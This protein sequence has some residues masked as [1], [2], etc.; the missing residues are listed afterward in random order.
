MEKAHDIISRYLAGEASPS[1]VQELINWLQQSEENRR[2]YFQLKNIWDLSGG[3]GEVS[4]ADTE[5][6]LDNVIKK[7]SPLRK[8]PGLWRLWQKIA[9][10]LIIPLILAGALYFYFAGRP[11][12]TSSVPVEEAR[13]NTVRTAH[14]NRSEIIL[15][16]GTKVLLDASSKITYPE[17]FTG[18]IREV[19]LEGQAYFQV[20]SNTRKPFIVSTGR[21]QIYATGT[22]F[23]I[24]DYG[25]KDE[26]K[27][28]LVAGKVAV[29]KNM[30]GNQK[31][32]ITDLSPDQCL[33][34]DSA[35]EAIKVEDGSTYEQV[36]WKDGLLVFRNEPMGKVVEKLS[37]VFEVDIELKDKSLENYRYRATFQDETLSEI[38]KLLKLSSPIDYVELK[39]SPLPDGSFEPR[40]VLIF[41]AEDNQ[42]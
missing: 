18:D 39:R 8:S 15:S 20:K 33:I 25:N 14:G 2:F 11:A 4:E 38:L 1:E 13:Y 10:I 40:K 3:S 36:A 29:S 23:D 21:L 12:D 31:K 42:N 41:R 34:Y 19:A 16:D 30:G 7:M 37:E 9:A 26:C 28:S 22:T 17:K 27:V 6:A 5:E 32:I 35:T 24:S